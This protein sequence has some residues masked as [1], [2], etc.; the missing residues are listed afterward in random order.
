MGLAPALEPPHREFEEAVQT[1]KRAALKHG[2][3][4]GIHCATPETV[5]RR[6]ADG[7][8]FMGILGDVRFLSAAAKAARDA[9]K[10][11]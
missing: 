5:N 8:R 2:V 11:E 4:P 10:T 9:I 7:W 3:P 1:V 6:I